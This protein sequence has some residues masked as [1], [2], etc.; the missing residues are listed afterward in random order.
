[1][2]FQLVTYKANNRKCVE[3]IVLGKSSLGKVPAGKTL[4][5]TDHKLRVPTTCCPTGLPGCNIISIK[6]QLQ[7]S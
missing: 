6:Y 4:E 1:V 3:E 5:G 2:F 7:V